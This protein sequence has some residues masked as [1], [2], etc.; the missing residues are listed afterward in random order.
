MMEA[1][2]LE[3]IQ[4]GCKSSFLD[5]FSFQAR[6]FYI[7]LGY[8]EVFVLDEYPLTSKRHYFVKKLKCTD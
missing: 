6:D 3:A 1:A 5:T 7:K 4:R 2:E 8:E